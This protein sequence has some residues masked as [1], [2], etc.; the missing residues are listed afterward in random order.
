MANREQHKKDK[1]N[2][3]KQQMQ[4]TPEQNK[5]LR[6]MCE[7]A[8]TVNGEPE[9]NGLLAF[10]EYLKLFKII[11]TLQCRY[12]IQNSEAS[13]AARRAAMANS[14]KNGFIQVTKKQLDQTNKTKNGVHLGVLEF[15]KIEPHLYDRTGELVCENEEYDRRATETMNKIEIAEHKRVVAQ[16]ESY[17]ELDRATVLKHLDKLEEKKA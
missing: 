14:D 3:Y 5:E 10:E 16:D 13:K 8:V 4:L 17:V 1:E 7:A 11:V 15:F 2:E 12:T 6:E 9:I